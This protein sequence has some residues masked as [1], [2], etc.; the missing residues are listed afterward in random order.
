MEELNETS[1]SGPAA[2]DWS[3]RGAAAVRRGAFAEALEAYEHAREQA[4]SA[5]SRDRVDLNIAMVRLQM[6]DAKGGEE[7]LREILLR[8][9]EDRTAFHAAY[10]LASS[11]RKQGR[12]ERALLYARR[13]MGRARETGDV[14]LVAPTHNLLGNILLTQNYLDE[15]LGEYHAALALRLEQAGDTRFSRAILEDNIGY[16]LI[17]QKRV[18]DGIRHIRRA[19][20]LAEETDDRRCRAEC[21]QDLCYALLMDGRWEDAVVEG[22]RALEDATRWD[23][24]DLVENCHYL[25]GE[26]GSRTGRH[27]LRDRHFEALQHR[28]PEVP[29][30]QEFLCSV[31]VTNFI[32]L[33]R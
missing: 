9:P 7:G 26:L 31:D 4:Q 15:A 11:L 14:D 20:E 23:F 1:G 16:C 2:P 5:H 33:R 12:H 17:L 18:A 8:A 27:D 13:A 22:E 6:G 32:T 30:L 10:N 3:E 21:L 29:F 28:H 19:L 24:P 25:L